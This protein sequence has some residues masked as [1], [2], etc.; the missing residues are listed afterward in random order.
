MKF[1]TDATE[2]NRKWRYI[3]DALSVLMLAITSAVLFVSIP[4]MYGDWLLFKEQV[5]EGMM[6]GLPRMLA[7]QNRWVQHH[8]W[9]AVLGV[10]MVLLIESTSLGEMSPHLSRM[11]AVYAGMSLTLAFLESLFAQ[12]VAALLVGARGRREDE[13]SEY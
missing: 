6:Q 4:R 11:T 7:D 12:K 13:P 1:C 5:R 3:V 9:P 10:G 8:F 2:S